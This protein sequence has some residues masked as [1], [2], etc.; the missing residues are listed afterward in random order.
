MFRIW[1]APITSSAHLHA[2]QSYHSKT[3]KRPHDGSHDAE[4]VVLFSVISLLGVL[5]LLCK[6]SAKKAAN[7]GRECKPM[8]KMN[9]QEVK[10]F[11]EKEF[12]SGVA[13]MFEGTA[14]FNTPAKATLDR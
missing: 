10:E 2:N 7:H 12:E 11:I 1:L 3:V 6:N 9:V 13:E 5:A 4:R 14:E 8:K